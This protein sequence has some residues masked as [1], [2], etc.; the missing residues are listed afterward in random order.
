MFPKSWL[1]D[2]RELLGL[3]GDIFGWLMSFLLSGIGPN[4]KDSR[5][6][7]LKKARD[8]GAITEEE[9]QAQRNRVMTK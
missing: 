6:I 9:Y 7:D 1:P 2:R 8:M 5:T 4:G 3:I